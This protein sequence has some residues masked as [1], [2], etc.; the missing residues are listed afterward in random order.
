MAF[1]PGS[2]VADYQEP[3]VPVE[4]PTSFEWSSLVYGLAGFAVVAGSARMISSYWKNRVQVKKEVNRR[5][6]F[7]DNANINQRADPERG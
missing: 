2:G 7:T 6:K 5:F 1:G 3:V 4:E